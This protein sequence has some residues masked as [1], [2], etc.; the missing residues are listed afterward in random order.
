MALVDIMKVFDVF[1]VD[2]P[3]V[4]YWW[5][6]LFL[7]CWLHSFCHGFVLCTLRP[8][9]YYVVLRISAAGVMN[10]IHAKTRFVFP[11]APV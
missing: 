2:A 5:L 1:L 6:I 9:K 3:V 10:N 7:F 4:F 8:P 11:R